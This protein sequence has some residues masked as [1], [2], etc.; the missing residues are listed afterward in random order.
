LIVRLSAI[1]DCIQT[2]PLACGLR[3][4]WPDSRITWA[5]ESPAAELVAANEAVDALV[6]LPRGF[7]K[8][9]RILW[10]L[11]RQLRGQKIDVA[12]DPQGLTKSGLVSCLSGA[13]RRIGFARPV[14]REFNPW[15]QTQLVHSRHE[16]RVDR[17][18]DLLAGA[19]MKMDGVVPARV[20]QGRTDLLRYN[21][22]EF[23]LHIPTSAEG[24]LMDLLGHASLGSGYAA[25]NPGAGWD[26]KRWPLEN[27]ATVARHLAGRGLGCV[28]TWGGSKE[29]AWAEE[30]ARLAGGAAKLAPP[31]S[32][33]ELGA[34]LKRARFFVGSDTGPLHLAAALG[35]PCIALFGSSDSKG[36]GPYG[37][38]HIVLQEALDLSPGRKRPG[39][40][41]WAMRLISPAA[42]AAACDT[43]LSGGTKSQAA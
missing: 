35:T 38:G 28:V 43:L 2:M 37:V 36:C 13:A 34:I 27:F 11:R 24:C 10:E 14:A 41:N 40:D 16:H 8:S 19:E 31:T 7:A 20:G 22:P 39:A 26:S 23:G 30:I 6:V 5:V 32:L 9:P 25:L 33:L 15:F 29:R 12:F 3:R 18:L 42:V 4:A 21:R 17:Y 1:G